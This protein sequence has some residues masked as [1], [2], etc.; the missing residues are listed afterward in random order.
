MGIEYRLAHSSP[1]VLKLSH[2]LQSCGLSYLGLIMG[3]DVEK[4]LGIAV[5][6][7]E[8][9]FSYCYIWCF[10]LSLSAPVNLQMVEMSWWVVSLTSG[11]ARQF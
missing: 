4:L 7:T 9:R 8:L 11:L 1:L 5:G 2:F 10:I 6:G 3:T